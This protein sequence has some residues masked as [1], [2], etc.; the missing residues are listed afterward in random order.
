MS[1][2]C[3]VMLTMNWSSAL[4][5]SLKQ[6]ELPPTTRLFSTEPALGD[7]TRPGLAWPLSDFLCLGPDLCQIGSGIWMRRSCDF[8][9]PPL[10]T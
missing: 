4:G 5:S 2:M 3:Y 9:F 1:Y 6:N 7:H 8:S 10:Y